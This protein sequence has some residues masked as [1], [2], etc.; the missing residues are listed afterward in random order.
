M[1]RGRLRSLGLANTLV[2]LVFIVFMMELLF[3]LWSVKTD[4]WRSV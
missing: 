4:L 1:K 3:F 2:T